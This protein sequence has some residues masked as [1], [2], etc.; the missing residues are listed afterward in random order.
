MIVSGQPP[1]EGQDSVNRLTNAAENVLRHVK[2]TGE[3]MS[4]EHLAM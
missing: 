1:H 3:L 2:H 4:I